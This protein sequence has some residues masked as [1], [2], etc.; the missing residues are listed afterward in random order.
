MTRE[1]RK[2]PRIQCS[3]TA[4]VKF[5]G[6]EPPV[7]AEIV[8]LSAGGCLLVLKEPR[9]LSQDTIVE[10]TFRINNLH[11]FQLPGQIKANR[12]D[13]AIGIQFPFLSHTL[14]KR[15]RELIG[16]LIQNLPD[17]DP[18]TDFQ[19]KRRYPRLG[20]IGPAAV[21]LA[22]GE[23]VIP[24]AIVDLSVGGCRVVLRQPQSLPEDTQ[25]E[26]TFSVHHLPFRVRGQV[27]AIRS[28]STIGF[29]FPVLSERVQKQI[30]DLMMELIAD[31]RKR[32]AERHRVAPE[33]HV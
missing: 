27:K 12:S 1:Q 18:P 16:H 2:Y 26:L 11:K 21:Q 5:A 20:C 8:N 14:H 3:G 13:N 32:Q 24:A 9:P 6:D 23:P 19:E 31:L 30:D 22:A 10:L 4:D 29:Q 33:M 25:V 28:D 15:L 17:T 7:P